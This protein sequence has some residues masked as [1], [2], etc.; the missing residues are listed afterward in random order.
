MLG[1]GLSIPQVACR[2]KGDPLAPAAPT[3]D[4]VA[5]SDTGSSS[6]DDITNDT[7]PDF[8]GS[9]TDPSGWLEND[10]VTLYVTGIA[11]I[12][13]TITAGEAG[14]GTVSLGLGASPLSDGNHSTYITHARG[15]HTSL[16]SNTVAL[17]VDT[18]A[19]TLSAASGSDAGSNTASISV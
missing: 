13:H 16:A 7:T 19:P 12:V 15:G 17:V 5:A 9:T 2:S 10:V 14:S 8:Y 11:P 4:L 18:V 1:T 3:L 6:T